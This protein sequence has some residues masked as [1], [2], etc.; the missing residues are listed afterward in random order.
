MKKARGKERG[1]FVLMPKKILI[2]KSD[3][4]LRI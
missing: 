1:L 2:F 3:V 4:F